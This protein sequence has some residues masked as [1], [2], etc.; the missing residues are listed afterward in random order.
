MSDLP[1]LARPKQPEKERERKGAGFFWSS[2]GAPGG[3]GPWRL[4]SDS[5]GSFI[6]S[7]PG[8]AVAPNGPIGMLKA[9]AGLGW[10]GAFVAL[11]GPLLNVAVVAFISYS[12]A[13]V[14]SFGIQR[15]FPY[16][17]KLAR[18]QAASQASGAKAAAP[19]A[20][21]PNEGLFG[22][23]PGVF[24]NSKGFKKD[25]SPAP[26]ASVLQGEAGG[27]AEAGAAPE[28]AAGAQGGEG[29]Q[30]AEGAAASERW[31]EALAGAQGGAG[32]G[33]ARLEPM[34]GLGASSFSSGALGSGGAKGGKGPAGAGKLGGGSGGSAGRL[35]AFKRGA[36]KRGVIPGNRI[37][38]ALPPSTNV[39]QAL[40]GTQ[41]V[42]NEAARISGREAAQVHAGAPFDSGG[43][44]AQQ[45]GDP[46]PLQGNSAGSGFRPATS[47]RTGGLPFNVNT[48]NPDILRPDL[49]D[50]TDRYRITDPNNPDD[51]VNLISTFTVNPNADATI[52]IQLIEKAR[53]LTTQAKDNYNSGVANIAAGGALEAAGILWATTCAPNVVACAAAAAM[54]AQGLNMIAQGIR[55]LSRSNDQ[56][57]EAN[58]VADE[59]ESGYGQTAGAEA[60]DYCVAQAR[61]GNQCV[62]RG[63]DTRSRQCGYKPK[64]TSEELRAYSICMADW[65]P[66]LTPG[67]T[68]YPDG[69][70]DPSDPNKICSSV[71]PDAVLQATGN[72]ARPYICVRTGS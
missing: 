28:G 55:E 68:F 69:R 51:G 30:D 67:R 32:A 18:K 54:I 42:S 9:L 58:A 47:G 26:D 21:L 17:P 24:S 5:V 57:N 66:G 20:A 35:T 62:F 19:N 11:K 44:G 45:V 63:N 29:A 34:G 43:V 39:R 49:G 56:A 40:L 46:I 53:A 8:Q 31:A 37:T 23:L 60:I 52:F 16:K 71:Y 14:L 36:P 65:G 38:R 10:K 22:L 13:Q 70:P 64:M 7:L 3:G 50:L 72:P 48:G 12:M 61:Q 41:I 25:G 6:R 33:S 1:D 2:S 59:I 4:I 15:A 27:G